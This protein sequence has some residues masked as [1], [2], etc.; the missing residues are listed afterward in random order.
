LDQAPKRLFLG[1]PAEESRNEILG[2]A[3][4]RRRA[5]RRQPQGAE[6]VEAERLYADDVGL[7]R[8]AIE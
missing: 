4:R 2:E 8:L 5:E 3:W 7:N 1:V 6:L